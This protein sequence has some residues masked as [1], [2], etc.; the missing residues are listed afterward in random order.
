MFSCLGELR[1][2]FLQHV[3]GYLW[4][5]NHAAV[6]KWRTRL[7]GA[8]ANQSCLKA[9]PQAEFSRRTVDRR[10][11]APSWRQVTWRL[12]YQLLIA[13]IGYNAECFDLAQLFDR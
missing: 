12:P 5:D 1:G 11:R 2:K 9:L 10:Q 3:L 8:G 7:P 13:F 6:G 4:V